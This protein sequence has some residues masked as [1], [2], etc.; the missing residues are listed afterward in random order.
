[1]KT[2][3]AGVMALL[4]SG[5]VMAEAN[6]IYVPFKPDP[7]PKP[8]TRPPKIY[9]AGFSSHIFRVTDFQDAGYLEE[10]D[11]DN[12]SRQ[13]GAKKKD[14]DKYVKMTLIG[15]W[16][17]GPVPPVAEFYSDGYYTDEIL[18]HLIQ[19]MRLTNMAG[20]T[21][22]FLVFRDATN[23]TCLFTP[24]II[25]ISPNPGRIL[26]Y[27]GGLLDALERYKQGKSR[28]APNLLELFP[29]LIQQYLS[30]PDSDE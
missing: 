19:H 9:C 15:Y 30:E 26:G 14:W 20:K 27:W 23:Y 22:E 12:L 5:A 10:R 17:I 8:D 29:D 13:N 24:F 1:M 21:Y 2:L 7:P 3:F 11:M 28:T 6:Y 4:V 16:E 18:Y 25:E